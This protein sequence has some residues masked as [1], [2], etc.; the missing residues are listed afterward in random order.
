M[1][2]RGQLLSQQELIAFLEKHIQG[3]ESSRSLQDLSRLMH[4]ADALILNSDG[5]RRHEIIV[6]MF[7]E[8]KDAGQ[9][10]AAWFHFEAR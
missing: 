1:D 6:L 3:G 8:K 9:Q 7:L 10:P 2:L 4:R 5:E